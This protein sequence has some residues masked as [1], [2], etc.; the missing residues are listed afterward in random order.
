M[1]VSRWLDGAAD[2]EMLFGGLGWGFG[3]YAGIGQ[4]MI[5]VLSR[6]D[7]PCSLY[8]MGL[9]W[10]DEVVGYDRMHQETIHDMER[11]ACGVEP[12]SREATQAIFELLISS[13][14]HSALLG[15]NVTCECAD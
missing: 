3:M 9:R 10:M 1:M 6:L 12:Q 2:K 14:T 4:W 7:A 5:A 8:Q 15:L 13:Y 11:L